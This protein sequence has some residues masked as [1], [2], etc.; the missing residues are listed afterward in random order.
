M[1]DGAQSIW[2]VAV[3]ILALAAL[4]YALYAA[5]LIERVRTTAEQSENTANSA[6]LTAGAANQKAEQ[7]T[8]ALDHDDQP[9][10]RHA[11]PRPSPR[12]RQE[13]AA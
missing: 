9:S 6:A 7:L 13:T 5:V 8:A 11:R 1:S 3:T 4:T 2:L 10:G 12:P